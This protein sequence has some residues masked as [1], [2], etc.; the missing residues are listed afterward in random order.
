MATVDQF[1]RGI[2]QANFKKWPPTVIN[3]NIFS[4][5]ELVLIKVS[6]AG[7]FFLKVTILNQYIRGMFQANFKKWPPTVINDNI[8]LAQE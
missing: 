1:F 3:D 6:M 4:A 7:R 2:F 5:Q 8:F